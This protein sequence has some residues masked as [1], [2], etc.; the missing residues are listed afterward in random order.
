VGGID[1]ELRFDLPE[2]ALCPLQRQDQLARFDDDERVA[3]SN[4]RAELHRNFFHDAA[5][6][7][8]DASLIGGNE[9]AR[10]IDA[11]LHAH[12]LQRL[13]L[14]VHGCSVAPAAPVCAIC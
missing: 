1:P 13:C 11:P 10:Q 14:D 2:G 5:D 3:D 7:A 12:A 4:F 8:A 9:R 6:F